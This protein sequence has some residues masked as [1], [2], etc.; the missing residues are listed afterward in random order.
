M[1]RFDVWIGSILSA[2]VI[3]TAWQRWLPITMTEAL[4]FVT[5][6]IC[7]YLVVKENIWNYPIGIAN[8]IFFLI[9]FAQS[10]LFGDA[11]LQI[12]Y[13]ALGIHGWYNWLFGGKNRSSLQIGRATSQLLIVTLLLIP[14]GTWGLV[15][16]LR[17]ANGAAPLL[18]AF[19]TI[20]SLAAQ[21]WLNRKVLENWLLW[22]V[23]DVIYVFL[24]ITRGLHLTAVLYAVFL[25]LCVAGFW[26]WRRTLQP[27]A[28]AF[29]GQEATARG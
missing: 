2:V 22:I 16:V 27:G 24:Y 9:L 28:E 11:G 23:A 14:L 10:R 12:V 1:K 7:V 17:A 29:A 25:C 5:G 3:F 26:H 4:G 8:N 18:D 15:L 6:A 19:T 13:L 20:L 21:Y